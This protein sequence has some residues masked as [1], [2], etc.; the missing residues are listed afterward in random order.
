MTEKYV[1]K[2]HPIVEDGQRSKTPVHNENISVMY[3]LAKIICSRKKDF[4]V[5][6]AKKKG[7]SKGSTAAA[8]LNQKTKKNVLM[9][10][11]NVDSPRKQNDNYSKVSDG[12][13]AYKSENVNN[14][15]DSMM[16]GSAM[17]ESAMTGSMGGATQSVQYDGEVKDV[18]AIQIEG[19]DDEGNDEEIDEKELLKDIQNF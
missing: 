3:Y 11:D 2:Y 13:V 4:I 7:I 19:D 10:D 1:L 15:T 16:T 6:N 17:T 9:D 18:E 14:I 12:T 5:E 8:T